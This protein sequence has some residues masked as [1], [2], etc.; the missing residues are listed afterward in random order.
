[1]HKSKEVDMED[2]E[3]AFEM[4]QTGW[5]DEVDAVGL[6]ASRRAMSHALAKKDVTVL[7]SPEGSSWPVKETLEVVAAAAHIIV[8]VLE[9]QRAR[10]E[11][12][13]KGK[14]ESVNKIE[15]VRRIPN[16]LYSKA[17]PD[18]VEL[19]LKSIIGAPDQHTE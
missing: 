13:D 4:L 6:S 5:E 7:T 11:S 19:L 17:G 10:S 12:K 15:I 2:E 8:I 14:D 1:V 9:W 16:E 18:K 3:R